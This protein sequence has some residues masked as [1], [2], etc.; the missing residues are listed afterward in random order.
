[1]FKSRSQLIVLSF[2]IFIVSN[3][4]ANKHM[5]KVSRST[6][7]VGTELEALPLLSHLKIMK[8]NDVYQ[9]YI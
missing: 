1:M 4:N 9:V 3:N 6:F 5:A 2:N 8:P 7:Y